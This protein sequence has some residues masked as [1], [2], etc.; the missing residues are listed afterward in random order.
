ML[1]TTDNLMPIDITNVVLFRNAESAEFFFEHC[2]NYGVNLIVASVD[3][4]YPADSDVKEE[5]QKTLET[6]D[7]IRIFLFGKECLSYIQK[8]K[9]RHLFLLDDLLEYDLLKNNDHKINFTPDNFMFLIYVLGKSVTLTKQ[10]TVTSYND[11]ILRRNIN[12][13]EYD[14]ANNQLIASWKARLLGSNHTLKVE[15]C[16]DQNYLF[17]VKYENHIVASI[18]ETKD[19]WIHEDWRGIGIEK[20]LKTAWGQHK[21]D[22]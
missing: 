16:A 20:M 17:C 10:S 2:Y 12:P 11:L 19:L 9:S 7:R 8:C 13:F 15:S 18:T 1:N 5:L 4:V 6:D 14:Q 22:Q 3:G 21:N